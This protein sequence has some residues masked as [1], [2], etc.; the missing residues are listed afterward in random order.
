MTGRELSPDDG[1]GAAA[2]LHR[3]H[4]LLHAATASPGDATVLQLALIQA[5]AA[6]G[7]DSAVLGTIRDTDLV[8]VTMLFGAGEPVHDVG[9]LTLDSRYPLTDVIVRERAIWLTSFPEIQEAYP[10]GGTL[11]GKAFAGVPLL[12]RGV[13]LGAIGLI[14]DTS[15][16][17]FGAAERAFLSAV[18]DLCATV[19]GHPDA[20]TWPPSEMAPVLDT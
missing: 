17:D 3:L 5:V 10:R 9:A 7:A 12:Q 11:W 20:T 14:H 16:H 8:D 15:G 6:T 18:A 1:P 13:P 19:L 2:L 4:L